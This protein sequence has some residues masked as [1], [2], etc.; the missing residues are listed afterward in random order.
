MKHRYSFHVYWSDEDECY[1]AI[2]PGFAS[3]SAH[4]D[5]PEEARQEVQVALELTIESYQDAGWELPRPQGEPA[6]V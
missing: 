6:T 3:V 1:I 5:T 2:V 4:G